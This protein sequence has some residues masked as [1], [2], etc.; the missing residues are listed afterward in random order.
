MLPVPVLPEGAKGGEVTIHP[1]HQGDSESGSVLV[2]VP[3]VRAGQLRAWLCGLGHMP[4]SLSDTAR[5]LARGVAAQ[6]VS[7]LEAAWAHERMRELAAT[8][9]LTGLANRRS[10]L[11]RLASAL[12]ICR[13]TGRPLSIALVDLN[14]FK[15][16]NDRY[17]H[18]VGDSAVIQFSKFLMRNIRASDMVARFGGDEFALLFPETSQEVTE[19]ILGR[20]GTA[21]ISISDGRHG[22]LRLQSSWGIAAWPEDGDA[23]DSL[24][25]TADHR[26]YAMKRQRM[27]GA[28]NNEAR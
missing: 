18:N 25:Q 19:S 12:A 4:V 6:G 10:F 24:L 15:A 5:S 22:A 21:R 20:M 17:G 11:D 9:G 8:D 16:I 23:P 27:D 1:S 13:R 14:E 7:A 26:L 2:G 3:L 28:V